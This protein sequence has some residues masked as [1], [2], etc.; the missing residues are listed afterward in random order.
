MVYAA[1]RSPGMIKDEVLRSFAGANVL[2]T[3]GTGLIGRQVVSLLCD[4]GA[5]VK[6]VSLDR[7][8]LDDRAQFVVGDLTEFGFC[9]DVTRDM[10][11]VFHLAGIKGSADVS[12]THLASHFL[13]AL[14]SNT[15]VF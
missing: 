7:L 6:V 11:F 4:A 13:P 10:D 2:G 9:R 5:R 3:G 15:N 12:R 1:N 8:Q 14:L